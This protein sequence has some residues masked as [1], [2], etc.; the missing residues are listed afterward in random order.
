MV[1]EGLI[2]L[3]FADVRTIMAGMGKAMMGTGESSG[4]RRAVEAAE[5]AISNPLLD[6]V[7]MKGAS[8][9]LVSIT[10]GNDLTLYEVD[11]AASRVRAEADPDANIIVGATFDDE[12]DGSIRVS[13]V[14]TGIGLSASAQAPII[15]AARQASPQP[16]RSRLS[17]RLAGLATL[18]GTGTPV[19]LDE[20]SLVLAQSEVVKD[21]PVW[22]APGN[23]T[24]EKRPAQATGIG[25]PLGMS[26][27][28]SAPQAPSRPFQP[29][30][31][32]AVRRPV[33]RMPSIDELPVVAQNAIKAKTGDSPGFGLR[34]QKKKVGFLERL[35]NVGRTRKEPDAEMPAKREPEFGQAFGEPKLQAPRPQPQSPVAPQRGIR[36]ERPRHE[37]AAPAAPKR[38]EAPAR[39][40]AVEMAETA[41]ESF[42]DDDLEIPAFLRRRA[43]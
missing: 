35:A 20:P 32:S 22:R 34:E 14:A 19:D 13:V 18:P 1:K 36:I 7:C 38:I 23:V 15:E 31:P 41:S 17:E 26:Q 40:V 33:R 29:A 25:L 42:M 2:N 6:D 5:A 4:D 43:N 16:E 28:K 8:G 30:P 3:D 37:Q 9:L 24:I 27:Q 12:L 11:E 10:G 21:P 39:P